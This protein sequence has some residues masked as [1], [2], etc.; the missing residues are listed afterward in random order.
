MAGAGAREP[1]DEDNGSSSLRA[2]MSSTP[3]CFHHGTKLKSLA[4]S[5]MSPRNISGPLDQICH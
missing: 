3:M 2:A 5:T 1:D 4:F